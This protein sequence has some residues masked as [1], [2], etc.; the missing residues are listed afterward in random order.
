MKSLDPAFLE[1][2]TITAATSSPVSIGAAAILLSSEKFAKENGIRFRA[3]INGRSIA[4]VDWRKMGTGPIPAT[5]CSRKS[6][7]ENERN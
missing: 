4:G 3:K 6:A 1:N 2:G 5:K 7:Y